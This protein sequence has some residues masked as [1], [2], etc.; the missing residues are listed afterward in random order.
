MNKHDPI[1]SWS[2]PAYKL[3]MSHPMQSAEC[4]LLQYTST[5]ACPFCSVYEGIR[6]ARVSKFRKA[7][8]K[9]RAAVIV[10]PDS[11]LFRRQRKQHQEEGKS[12]PE[13]VIADMRGMLDSH[14][15]YS[16]GCTG[17]CQTTVIGPAANNRRKSMLS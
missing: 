6:T 11:S 3:N 17:A 16:L 9:T 5:A 14:R 1:P 12:V 4:N 8:F 13:T 10:L 7:G 15:L 2:T